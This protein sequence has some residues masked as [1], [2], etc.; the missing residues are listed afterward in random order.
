MKL[1]RGLTARTFFASPNVVDA[2]WQVSE[3]ASVVSK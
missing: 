2:W 1:V 3:A